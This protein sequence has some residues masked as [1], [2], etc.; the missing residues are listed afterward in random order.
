MAVFCTSSWGGHWPFLPFLRSPHQFFLLPWGGFWS[1]SLI[2]NKD[3]KVPKKSLNHISGWMAFAERVNKA[4]R[5]HP[6]CTGSIQ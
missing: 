4:G 3:G 5:S 6:E 2:V 1:P